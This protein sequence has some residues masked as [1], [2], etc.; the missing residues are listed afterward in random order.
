VFCVRL[1]FDPFG[2]K[3]ENRS[4][5]FSF[6]RYFRFF[7]GLKNPGLDRPVRG[8]RDQGSVALE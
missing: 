6:F 5:T 1:G 4:E 3:R 8:G 2:T 7:R